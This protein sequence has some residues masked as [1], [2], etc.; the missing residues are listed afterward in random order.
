MPERNSTKQFQCVGVTKIG[1]ICLFYWP[2]DL[3]M[4]FCVAY[5]NG[6]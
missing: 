4:S 3:G 5:F 1:M 2:W 6:D